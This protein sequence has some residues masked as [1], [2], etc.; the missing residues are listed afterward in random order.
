MNGSCGLIGN[1]LIYKEM[2]HAIHEG[3]QQNSYDVE[4]QSVGS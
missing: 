1:V 3:K 4:L 2:L